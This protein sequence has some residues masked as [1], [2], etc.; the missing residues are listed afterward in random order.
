MFTTVSRLRGSLR[1]LSFFSG[2]LI[3]SLDLHKAIFSL[4]L[5]EYSLLKHQYIYGIVEIRLWHY[6]FNMLHYDH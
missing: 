3:K 4:Y 2:I 6:M 1:W 5:V